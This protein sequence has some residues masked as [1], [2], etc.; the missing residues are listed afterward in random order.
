M[1][2]KSAD[3]MLEALKRD[4]D[5]REIKAQDVERA[6]GIS[7]ATLSHWFSG[8]NRPTMGPLLEVLEVLG[9]E[10]QLVRKGKKTN[11]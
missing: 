2:I 10:L 6:A 11:G 1:V 7:S 3:Q 8:R 4:M 9:L 5:R